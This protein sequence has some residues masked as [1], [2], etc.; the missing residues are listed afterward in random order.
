M[1]GRRLAVGV[2]VIWGVTTLMFV[3]IRVAPGDPATTLLGPDATPEQIEALTERLGL[4][5]NIVEQYLAYLRQLAT[6]DFGDS[7]R[8]GQPAIALVSSRLPETLQLT[9]GATVIAAAVGLTLSLLA[10][11]RPDGAI[12]R[13][14]S[15]ISILF[16]GMPTFWVG[17]MLIL[18]FALVLRVTPSSGAGTPAHLILPAITLALPF[19]AIIAR[20][21]RATLTEAM[22]EPYVQ[23]ARAK[24]LSRGEALRNHAF[25][26][27]MG[28]VVTIVGLQVGALVGGAVVVENVFAWPGL[29]TLIVDSVASRDY[30]VVQ[31]AVFVIALFVLALNL[32]AD[33]V[34]ALLDPRIRVEANA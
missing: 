32:V 5:G 18:I 3:L 26:N 6:L 1:I 29:G 34:N 21:S 10:A 4:S 7:F 24:G 23:T 19:T 33:I 13:V 15:T 30:T 28:P 31:A 2:F 25:R 14:V 9:L 16:Q 27:A 12:D 17:I 8:T 11:R 22:R 20:I